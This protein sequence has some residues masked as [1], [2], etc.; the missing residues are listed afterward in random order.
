MTER[1]HTTNQIKR[2]A[3]GAG[4]GL[5]V[6]IAWALETYTGVTMPMEVAVAIGGVI[7]SIAGR[8]GD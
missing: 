3:Q 5:P 4:I 8:F 7:G 1:T 2:N 6:V